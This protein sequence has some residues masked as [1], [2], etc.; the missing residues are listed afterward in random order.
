M[1]PKH[2][3]SCMWQEKLRIYRMMVRVRAMEE[4][5]LSLQRQGRI[6]FYGSCYGQEA[7]TLASAAALGAEDWIFPGLREASAMLLRGYPL[8][9]WLAQL[10]G[11]QADPTKGRQMPSHQGDRGVHQA[12]WSSV[13]GTQ[14][15]QAVGAAYAAKR[16]GE[17]TV[18]AAYFG[19]GATSSAAF[20][21]AM[22]FARSLAAPVVFCCQ[23]NHW[24]ISVPL[25]RQTA[26]TRLFRKGEAF[27]I[28]RG[29]VDGNSVDAVYEATAA[30]VARARAGQ[31]P[32]LLELVTYRLG[33]HS[34]SDDPTRY[35]DQ[36]EVDGWLAKEPIG[37]T[38]RELIAAGA[39]SEASA[40]AA[41][42]KEAAESIAE[43]IVAA[44]NFPPPPP[45]SLF[46]DVYADA[47]PWLLAWSSAAFTARGT[48]GGPAAAAVSEPLEVRRLGFVEYADGLRLMEVY[49]D[50]RAQR[51]IADTLFL[52]E[53]LPVLT[54]GR[55]GRTNDVLADSAELERRGIRVFETDRGGEGTY[56][57]PGQVV[58]YPIVDLSP[59]RRDVRRYVRDLEET[60]LRA[61]LDAGVRAGRVSGLNGIWLAPDADPSS[62]GPARKLGALGVH[63][64]RWVTSHGFALNV[65]TDLAAFDLI[66]ACGIR[67]RGV[68]LAGQRAAGR[69]LSHLGGGEPR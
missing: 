28:G 14:L 33:A 24:S 5:M 25:S 4:R 18:V 42:Q 1:R 41:L 21:Q 49:R 48:G 23:N 66:V 61:A 64:S 12:S 59:D 2:P 8:I 13:I 45:E 53:H 52:L 51:R 67:D 34:S 58:G 6:G 57:G 40:I 26:E 3:R 50:A 65:N 46:E 30:A 20:S 36:K 31:G 39:W 16:R 17:K 9:P 54:L 35:R 27:G 69:P 10:F 37:R 29:R 7:A 15:P 55:K 62:P 60:M 56:H 63:L 22:L 43:G 68:T 47:S 38:K 19:D 32:S 11:N 44:E